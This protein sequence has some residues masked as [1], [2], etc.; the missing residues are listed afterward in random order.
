MVIQRED[1]IAVYNYKKLIIII[2]K[3]KKKKNKGK[4]FIQACAPFEQFSIQNDN[5]VQVSPCNI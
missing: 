3:K 4:M 2:K 1:L 5:K